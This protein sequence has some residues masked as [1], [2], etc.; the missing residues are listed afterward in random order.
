MAISRYDRPARTQ[1]DDASD[2]FLFGL[3]RSGVALA[4]LARGGVA[5]KVVAHRFAASG[6]LRSLA[7]PQAL[8]DHLAVELGKNVHDLKFASGSGEPTGTPVFEVR[9]AH[10]R[11]VVARA[12]R[13]EILPSVLSQRTLGTL[14]EVG[15]GGLVALEKVGLV[16]ALAG[17]HLA[18]ALRDRAGK[19]R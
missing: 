1:L 19:V 9:T 17:T 13:P 8:L 16:E 4:S 18:P 14:L 2:G 6:G 11:V 10:R 7:I 5:E 3:N 12:D 15:L